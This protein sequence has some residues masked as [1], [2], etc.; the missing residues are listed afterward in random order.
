MVSL[1]EVGTFVENN[2]VLLSKLE[3]DGIQMYLKE[4]ENGYYWLK[5]QKKSIWMIRLPRK[6]LTKS[7]N[8]I[9]LVN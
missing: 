9:D 1:R 4:A 3:R 8:W 5:G 2:E 7:L 6:N